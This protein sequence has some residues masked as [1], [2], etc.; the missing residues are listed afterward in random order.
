M[1]ENDESGGED[2]EHTDPLSSMDGVG[3]EGDLFGG[4]GSGNE[5]HGK[6]IIN[7]L[8]DIVDIVMKN[9]E[10]D[11]VKRLDFGDLEAA[12]EF[13]YW[14]ARINGFCIR[15]KGRR[16]DRGLTSETRKREPKKETRCDCK[17]KFRVHVDL[18]CQWS[19]TE[20]TDLHSHELLEDS[21]CSMLPAHRRMPVAD[22]LLIE[23]FRKVGIRPPPILGAFANSSAFD[24]TYRKKKY[25][26][27]FV[28]FLGVNHHNQT[29]VFATSLV[30]NETEQ[31]YVWLLEQFKDVMK[32][33]EPFSLI[34]DGDLVIRNSIRRVFPRA[35]HRLC[36]WHLLWNA[37]SHVCNP[38]MMN[39]LK[40][41]LLIMMYPNLKNYRCIC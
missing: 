6:I 23:N 15:K 29:I 4:G 8:I 18:H 3:E 39:Y 5:E 24:A 26:F 14:Y 7:A 33:K 34:T 10:A 11:V 41:C 35:H 28:I 36:A 21:L 16:E 2:G 32:G 27:P 17:A 13:Y 40:N 38:A 31:T 30:S 12:Y 1:G 19:I 9:L 20:F 37:N 25:M 22:I